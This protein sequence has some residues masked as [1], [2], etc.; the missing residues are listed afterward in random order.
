M[1]DEYHSC[2]NHMFDSSSEFQSVEST[3]V[4]GHHWGSQRCQGTNNDEGDEEEET[5][6]ECVTKREENTTSDGEDQRESHEDDDVNWWEKSQ[7]WRPGVHIIHLNNWIKQLRNRNIKILNGKWQWS[8]YKFSSQYFTEGHILLLAGA[9]SLQW[10]LGSLPRR[11][12]S[13]VSPRIECELGHGTDQ[14]SQSSSTSISSEEYIAVLITHDYF[15]III[16]LK[17]LR[18]CYICRHRHNN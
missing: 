5:G 18:I 6:Q 13:R 12:W 2:C 15:V 17:M 1:E 9:V 14:W 16:F 11:G 4:L 3:L 8:T 7:R 10:D